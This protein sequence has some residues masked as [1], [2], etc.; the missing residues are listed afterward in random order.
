MVCEGATMKK[1]YKNWYFH[2]IIGHPVMG[3]IVLIAVVFGSEHL[4]KL[5]H[6]VHDVTLP[7]V[8]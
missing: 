6:K 5:A 7:E 3:I 4:K 8:L 1:L 2:N